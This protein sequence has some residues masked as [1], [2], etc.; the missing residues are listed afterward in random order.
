MKTLRKNDFGYRIGTV[1]ASLGIWVITKIEEN[2]DHICKQPNGFGRAVKLPKNILVSLM[3]VVSHGD[4]FTPIAR[5]QPFT[6]FNSR[7]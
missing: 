3:I 4:D 6:K 1:D 2:T 5:T 7:D